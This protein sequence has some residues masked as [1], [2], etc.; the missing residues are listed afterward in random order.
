MAD[1]IN[2][3]TDGVEA[4]VADYV[5]TAEE[6]KRYMA[7]NKDILIQIRDMRRRISEMKNTVLE[8]MEATGV[9]RVSAGGLVVELKPCKRVKHD[10]A[11]LKRL[12]GDSVTDEYMEGVTE[13]AN[14]VRIGRL[15]KKNKKKTN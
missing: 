5:E 13:T 10:V 14:V 11:S 6:L 8:S 1:E 9:S 15:K 2:E 12:A 4:N 7:E 3:N